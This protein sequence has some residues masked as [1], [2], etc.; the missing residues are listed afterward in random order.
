[1]PELPEVETVRRGVEGALLGKRIAAVEVRRRDLRVVVPQ[2]FEALIEGRQVL[3]L[4]RR[5]KYILFEFGD[6]VKAILHLGMSG[7]M[8]IYGSGQAYDA[9]PHDHI[10][11]RADDGT[12][13]VFHDPRRFGMFYTLPAGCDWSAVKPFSEMGPEPVDSA[14][15]GLDLY[16]ALRGRKAPIKNALLDQNVVAGLGNIYVCEALFEAGICPQ[17]LSCS[18]SEK[19]ADLLAIHV[20]DVLERAIAAGGSTLKDYQH[21]DGSLGYF[22]HGF[23]V[24]GRGGKQCVSKGCDSKILRIVQGG[25]STF[26]CDDCQK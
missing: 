25:R 22:Q 17:R 24:Y 19:E 10:V 18:L 12:M 6:S 2:D 9:Q 16:R 11:L 14:W 15:G 26:Y 20:K 13:A 3:G 7:R 23:K 21:T 8:R 5:G 4:V 1:M